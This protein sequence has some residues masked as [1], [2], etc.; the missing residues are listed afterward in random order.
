MIA[1]TDNSIGSGIG[2][3]SISMAECGGGPTS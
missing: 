3:K 1:V 2:R